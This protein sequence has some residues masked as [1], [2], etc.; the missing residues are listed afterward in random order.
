MVGIGQGYMLS[1][2]LQL[3]VATA[4]VARR[5]EVPAPS[6]LKRIEEETSPKGLLGVVEAEDRHWDAVIQGMRDV[7][8]GARGTARGSA[9]GLAYR[10]AGKTGTSQVVGIP[11]GE[12]Y[13][14]DA[15]PPA[16]AR[17][18]CSWDTRHWM[19]RASRSP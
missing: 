3:A 14:R 9:Q 12:K 1:T 17:M 5:G 7:M 11:Q 18:P 4:G 15:V 8:H 10:M 19:I 13:D 2:P 6:L 16:S